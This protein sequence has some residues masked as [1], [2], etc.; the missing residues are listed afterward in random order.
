MSEAP[1]F[2]EL[3]EQLTRAVSEHGLLDFDETNPKHWHAAL[4]SVLQAE[5]AV[6]IPPEDLRVVRALLLLMRETYRT[7]P[8]GWRRLTA[9]L[10]GQP[11]TP[12]PAPAAAPAAAAAPVPRRRRDPDDEP[13][14]GTQTRYN[15]AQYRCR[16]DLCRAA[17]TE[18]RR[19]RKALMLQNNNEQED[20][21]AES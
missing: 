12:A 9:R 14:H 8:E 7:T 13:P 10:R 19:T 3:A 2:E 6:H 20:E 1:T 21:Q 17:N 16:C 18:Y 5:L 15:S 11:G 4:D